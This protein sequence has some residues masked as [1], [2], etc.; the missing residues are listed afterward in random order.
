M[1]GPVWLFCLC[2]VDQAREFILSCSAC[3]EESGGVGDG[4]RK[5][6]GEEEKKKK[7]KSR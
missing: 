4:G 6:E 1:N 2:L 7:D 3:P 5:Q